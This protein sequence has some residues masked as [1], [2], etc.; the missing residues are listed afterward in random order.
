M[1]V[2][3]GKVALVTGGGS[4]LGRAVVE[5]FV[6]EGARVGVL[7]RS[8][9]KAD[10]L[11]AALGEAVAVT[12]GD[13]RSPADN[14][15]AVARTVEAFGRLDVFVGNAGVWD[16]G[17]SLVDIPLDALGS[18]FE[19]LYSVNVKGY[20]LGARAA[21]DALRDSQ[22]VMI[23]TLSNAA[24]LPGGGGP[25]YTSSKHAIVGLV[26]QLAYELE[27][28]VRVN[29]VA[30]GLMATDLR[31]LPSLNQDTVS[32]GDLVRERGGEDAIAQAMG[33]PFVPSAEHYVMGYL[34]LASGES[35]VTNGAILEM[36]GLVSAPP[37]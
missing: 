25:L 12:Q 11:T 20:L 13:V 6:A 2:L 27:N 7:E 24:F 14:S 29:G 17:T 16:F 3:N 33:K 19:E 28:Q 32:L 10:D 26:R 31:G 35:P 15:D 4:G 9:A 18:A 5:R 37:R 8:A 23:F 30:P 21:V 36:H 34:L 1:G 22:G